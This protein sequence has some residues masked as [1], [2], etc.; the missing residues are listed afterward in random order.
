MFFSSFQKT[1][2]LKNEIRKSMWLIFSN[3]WQSFENLRRLSQKNLCFSLEMLSNWFIWKKFCPIRLSNSNT[4]IFYWNIF[5]RSFY[6][7]IY[8]YTSIN[9]LFIAFLEK[10]SPNIL[11]FVENFGNIAIE[12]VEFKVWKWPILWNWGNIWAKHL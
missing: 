1:R 11:V 7:T 8:S 4:A 12:T 2:C 10:K 6:K 9:S 5:S 3:I